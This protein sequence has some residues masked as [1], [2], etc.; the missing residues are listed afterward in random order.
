MFFSTMRLIIFSQQLIIEFFG[1]RSVQRIFLSIKI[2]IK[3]FSVLKH[4][5]YISSLLK[6]F[7]TF[8]EVLYI[9]FIGY[10]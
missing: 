4:K 2:S 9:K 3:I 6:F 1:L 8:I 10:L 7:F 5:E